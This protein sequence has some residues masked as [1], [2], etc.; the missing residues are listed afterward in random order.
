VPI[1][2]PKYNG[3]QV[4]QSGLPT[5]RVP[6]GLPSGFGD[7]GIQQVASMG[8]DLIQKAKSDADQL[9]VMEADKKLTQLETD[10]LY[11]P[12]TGALNKRGKDS[13]SAPDEVNE[14]YTKNVSD[15]ENSLSN[16]A[17]KAA[18]KRMAAERGM[19]IDRSLQK[20]VAGEIKTYDD[21][22][23][24]S[25]VSSQQQTAIAGYLDGENVERS[26]LNQ[27]DAIRAHA[28][29]NG[30]PEETVLQRTETAASKTYSS[31]LQRMMDDG[32]DL[33]AQKYYEA[34]KEKILGTDR[35]EIEKD[36]EV[37][38]TMGFAQRE[39]DRILASGVSA[40]QAYEETKKVEDPK[41]RK[42]LEEQISRQLNIKKQAERE[43]LDD[44]HRNAKNILD[45][46]RGDLS[47]IPPSTMRRFSLSESSSLRH[48]ADMLQS[49]NNISTDRQTL[50]DLRTL[51]S[52]PSTQNDFLQ[53]DLMRPEYYSKLSNSDFEEMVKLQ[54]SLRKGK[55]DPKLSEFRTD[56]QV[57]SDIM[58]EYKI[59]KK[60][61]ESFKL[62]NKYYEMLE[63]YKAA[64]GKKPG[65]KEMKAIADQ[66]MIEGITEKNT[67][68]FDTRKRVYQLERNESFVDIE[69]PES[70]KNIIEAELKK[71]GKP[72]SDA[73]IRDL[74][75]RSKQRGG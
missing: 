23:T 75:V 35:A 68:W 38:S 52:N 53:L 7:T 60:S 22:E 34:N 24:L 45:Q 21:Q 8:V 14:S 27:Q 36:L 6:A 33:L 63:E 4:Q 28:V 67:F 58:G 19:N 65:S 9:A 44:M 1:T 12:E 5:S 25:Y 26:I 40:S 42:A 70:D 2:V 74:Y 10:L 3:P 54:G 39:A 15:I 31:V 32:D 66:L 29:R 64:N 47:K 49:N 73:V 20:H 71:R 46:T 16:P 37:S 11:N 13:F 56:E 57:I 51:A 41:K 55:Q 30:L 59:N 48:Y 17:Q 18:F 50:Y 43:D 72:V 69:V 61:D 62:K